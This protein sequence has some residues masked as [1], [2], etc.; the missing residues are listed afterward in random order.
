MRMADLSALHIGVAHDSSSSILFGFCQLPNR[1]L[2]L[3]EDNLP[4]AVLLDAMLLGA[5]AAA[6]FPP[7]VL[8][9]IA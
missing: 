9:R 5:A 3:L 1:L 2:T 8:A 7:K 6:R 4:A